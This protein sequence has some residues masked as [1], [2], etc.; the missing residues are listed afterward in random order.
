PDGMSDRT[1]SDSS[2]DQDVSSGD[3]RLDSGEASVDRILENP[4]VNANTNLFGVDNNHFWSNNDI[5]GQSFVAQTSSLVA[6]QMLL[7]LHGTDPSPEI[8]FAIFGADANGDID[9]C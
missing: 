1:S 3:A 7:Y 6:G 8:Q 5:E 4:R 9:V 2:G